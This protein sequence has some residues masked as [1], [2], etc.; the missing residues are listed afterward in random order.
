M[1]DSNLKIN[2]EQRNRMESQTQVKNTS[3]GS[4]TLMGISELEDG[5]RENTQSEQQRVNCYELNC[6]PQIYIWKT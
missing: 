2:S 3:M 4:N 5:T 1:L 6:V